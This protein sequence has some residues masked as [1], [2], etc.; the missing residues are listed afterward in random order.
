MSEALLNGGPVSILMRS[1]DIQ[2]NLQNNLLYNFFSV[3][4]SKKH[5]IYWGLVHMKQNCYEIFT[6][7]VIFLF[8][9]TYSNLSY[10]IP[11]HP[12]NVPNEPTKLILWTQ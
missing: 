12:M 6:I 3:A 2:Q 1:D 5:I 9:S 4:D 8:Y 10:P 11:S 7:I